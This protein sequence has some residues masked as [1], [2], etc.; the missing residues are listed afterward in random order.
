LREVAAAARDT[1]HPLFIKT[2]TGVG[3]EVIQFPYVPALH[4]LADKWQAVRELQP[5]GVQQSWLFF[6]MFGSRAEELALWAAY[7]PDLTSDQFLQRMAVRDFGPAAAAR[8]LNSWQQ[9]SEA[10][11]HLPCV[12]LSYYYVGPGFLGPAHP[13]V[14]E[15]G[16]AIPDIFSA[17]FF[18][19]LEDEETFSLKSLQ[20]T[21]RSMVMHELPADAGALYMQWEGPGDGWDIV[22][23]EYAAAAAAAEGAWQALLAARAHTITAVDLA[24]LQ[25]EL[26]LTELFYRTMLTCL[27]TVRFLWQRR[28][29]ERSG[30][31]EAGQAEAGLAEARQADARK[32]MR[33]IASRERANAAAAVPLYSAAP[34]LDLHERIDGRFA[35]CISMIEEKVRWIDRFLQED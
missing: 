22:I 1:A 9:M 21:R 34:W 35:P 12:C 8:V 32:A 28:E 23:R 25:E 15:R 19:L 30:Q 18:Y 6:G 7:R 24:N 20:E 31:A 11:R 2:E 5:Q 17:Y 4:H 33:E 26:I 10:V 13:L 29:F 3:L 14:P 16:A 27:N